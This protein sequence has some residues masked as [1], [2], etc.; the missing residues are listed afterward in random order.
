MRSPPA[1]ERRGQYSAA[2]PKSSSGPQRVRAA[3]GRICIRA[4]T[5]L[6]LLS[7][8][9]EGQQPESRRPSLRPLEIVHERP[10]EVSANVGALLDRLMDRRDMVAHEAIPDRVRTIRDAVLRHVQWNAQARVSQELAGQ[11]R[12]RHLS[13]IDHGA[14][15]RRAL[16]MPSKQSV[17]L[18]RVESHGVPPVVI[19]TEEVKGSPE[20]RYALWYRPEGRQQQAGL[21]RVDD[22]SHERP[23]L[24]TR[25][26][27]VRRL[28]AICLQERSVDDD[29]DGAS[30]IDVLHRPIRGGVGAQH[31]RER[32]QAG[33]E[34][35]SPRRPLVHRIASSRDCRRLV[36]GDPKLDPGAERLETLARKPREPRDRSATLPPAGVRD[37]AR[38]GAMIERDHRA[39]SELPHA[40]ED[41]RVSREG[42]VVEA[43][44]LGLETAPL[45]SEPVRVLSE[46]GGNG[47][48]LLSHSLPPGACT[49]RSGAVV[50]PSRNLLPLGPVVVVVPALDLVRGRRSSPEEVRRKRAGAHGWNSRSNAFAVEAPF[51]NRRRVSRILPAVPA[52]P[53]GRFTDRRL[54]LDGGSQGS[55]DGGERAHQPGETEVFTRDC[56]V[57]DLRDRDG[58]METR[59]AHAVLARAATSPSDSASLARR[60]SPRSDTPAGWPSIR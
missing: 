46:T 34:I 26:D 21:Q 45:Q 16:H 10:V 36:Q 12:R 29:A 25:H 49:A 18:A 33:E 9:V 28:G 52:E 37:P 39:Q 1:G 48:I 50:D 54:T 19:E 59:P 38:Q 24:E 6:A 56:A 4:W 3:D 60:D 5:Q 43:A 32:P 35:S 20:E 47:K 13:P 15:H 11:P 2:S 17:L 23:V 14:P 44:L 8:H 51:R 55:T 22:G 57:V 42:G 40:I 7:G 27:P 31:G 58:G 30:W 41:A 53:V